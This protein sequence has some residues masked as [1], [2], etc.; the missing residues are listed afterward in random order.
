MNAVSVTKI[1]ALTKND[2]PSQNR[3]AAPVGR[4]GRLAGRRPISRTAT[5][6]R[7]ATVRRPLWLSPP[8]RVFLGAGV[9]ISDA[10][11]RFAGA[12]ACA[13]VLL[14]LHVPAARADSALELLAG[15]DRERIQATYPVDDS[16]A[17]GELAKLLYR[18]GN[19][20][21]ASLTERA[22]GSRGLG[23]AVQVGGR[24]ASIGRLAVP[25]GLVDLLGFSEIQR[26]ILAAEP[27]DAADQRLLL[28][29]QDLPPRVRAG[30]RVTA[31]GVVVGDSSSVAADQPPTA[32]ATASV[33]WFPADAAK[34]GWRLLAD[35]GV[36]MALMTEAADR[37]RQPLKAEDADA[38]YSL[39][40]ASRQIGRRDEAELPPARPVQPVEL[41]NSP[42][43]YVGEWIRMRLET[44]RV[45]RV[46][47]PE[48]KR[49]EQIGA[50]HYYQI[51]A[52]GDLGDVQIQ[53]QRPD[54]E[55]VHFENTYPVSVVAAQLP[56]SLERRIRE[57]A[58]GEA[59]VV[60]L[61]VPISLRGFFYRLWSYDSEFMEDESGAAQ[62]GPLIIAAELEHRAAG[63]SDPIGVSVIGWFAAA[64]VLI[65]I[66]ATFL[67]TRHTARRDEQIRRRRQQQESSRL[68][69]PTDR[70]ERPV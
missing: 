47:V 48:P 22:G 67:W 2:S 19:V 37:D 69:W 28:F 42:D 62:F 18:L 41:L 64:A 1:S 45:T 55:A 12:L 8:R 16:Q 35:A 6:F 11:G 57:K 5:V 68:Q 30:D 51:D 63:A 21:E 10:A 49:Q 9:W 40:S 15:F 44:V 13:V 70:G 60:L 61:D 17:A 52:V 34:P 4:I 31:L 3:S 59:A 26:L 54:G 14:L 39:L 38:F 29:T 7:T 66:V 33:E 25:E 56:K 53:I 36:D 32:V 27:S 23:D 46:A 58:G 20:S 65:V 50:D 43:D 24:I